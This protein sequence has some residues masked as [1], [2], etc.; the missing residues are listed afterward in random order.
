MYSINFPD[1]FATSRTKLIKDHDATLSNLKLLLASEKTSLFGDPYFGTILKRIIYE[2]N[3]PVLQD[4]VIDE[5]YTSI[6]MF[7]PQIKITRKDISLFSD[8]TN[9]YAKINCINLIDYTNNLYNIRLTNNTGEA[10]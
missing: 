4:L 7:M 10:Q 3:T 6:L 9:L 2:Q 8:G 5:I 1:M